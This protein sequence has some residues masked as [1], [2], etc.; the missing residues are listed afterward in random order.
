MFWICGGVKMVEGTSLCTFRVLFQGGCLFDVSMGMASQPFYTLPHTLATWTTYCLFLLLAY[1][2]C[3]KG[4]H[5]D[6]SIYTFN[7]L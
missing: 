1:I 7:V 2:N 6:I 4:F 3:I 5:R